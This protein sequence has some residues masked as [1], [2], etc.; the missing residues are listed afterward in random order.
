VVETDDFYA[1]EDIDLM[2]NF[3]P[4]H[5]AV[6]HK[7]APGEAIDAAARLPAFREFLRFSQ[8]PLWRVS[9]AADIENGKTVEVVDLRFGSP[10]APVFRVSATLDSR[11]RPVSSSFQF[12]IGRQK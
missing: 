8:F 5:A 4:T 10:S 7:P 1:V 11:L 12:G 2:G 9:P 3:D 6:Y